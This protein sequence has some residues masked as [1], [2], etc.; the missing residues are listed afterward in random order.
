M[1]HACPEDVEDCDLH[2]TVGFM[3]LTAMSIHALMD[4][5]NIS[6]GFNAGTPAGIAVT[7]SLLIHKFIDGLILVSL[8]HKSG[9]SDASAM[10]YC[11]I[12]A[13]FTLLGAVTSS[14]SF[15]MIGSSGKSFLLGFSSGTLIYIAM[16]DI[17][18]RLHKT[19]DRLCPLLFSA[20]CLIILLIGTH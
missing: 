14:Y 2:Q 1:M 20:G 9:K 17:L 11:I 3:A 10:M 12:L 15:N 19:N 18:P 13:A 8:L 6:A 16:A 5:F 4:G 7:A